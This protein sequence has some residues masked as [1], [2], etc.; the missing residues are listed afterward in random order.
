MWRPGSRNL[1]TYFSGCSFQIGNENFTIP[2][3]LGFG[4]PLTEKVRIIYP[5]NITNLYH[6]HVIYSWPPNG[7]DQKKCKRNLQIA[8]PA[9]LSQEQGLKMRINDHLTILLLKYF[10]SFPFYPPQLDLLREIYKLYRGLLAAKRD[11]AYYLHQALRLLILVR[12]SGEVT[13]D[14]SDAVAQEI[15]GRAFDTPLSEYEATHPCYIR[16]QL[17]SVFAELARDLLSDVLTRLEVL[18]LNKECSNWHVVFSTFAVL[19]MAI[20]L[21]QYQDARIGFHAALDGNLLHSPAFKFSERSQELENNGVNLLLRLYKLCFGGCNS[22]IHDESS[23]TPPGEAG[24]FLAKIRDIYTRTQPYL[25]R[26]SLTS[27]R[28]VLHMSDLFD[29]QVAK[30]IMTR[31]SVS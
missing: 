11:E 18:A 6:H 8:F 31:P 20:E 3:K 16:S 7:G 30:L 22:R 17:G 23:A 29:R 21:V 24:R 15:L 13:V 25:R 2:L 9:E 5:E 27:V 19:F 12:I 1:L 14:E 10:S 28:N 26:Q 4:E